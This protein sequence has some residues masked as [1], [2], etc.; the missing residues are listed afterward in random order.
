MN[1]AIGKLGRSIFFNKKAWS[2]T[3]GDEE[4]PLLYTMLAKRHPEHT[5]YLIGRSDITRYRA[6]TERSTV[7][8]L[9]CFFGDDEVA[10]TSNNL[11]TN[12]VDLFED[13][14][15]E[16]NRDPHKWLLEKIE[17]I[18]LKFDL[19]IIYHGPIA[20]V[21]VP[22]VGIMRVDGKGPAQTLDMFSKYYAPVVHTFNVMQFPWIGLCGDPK[23]VPM[24]Q[25]D[26]LN[27]PKIIMSQINAEFTR[28][29]IKSYTESLERRTVKETY[30]YCGIETIYM[31]DSERYD[32]RNVK[33]DIPFTIGLNGGDSRNDFIRE[34][35]IDKGRTDIKVYGV[36]SKE[37]TDA[38]P[39]MFEEK[40]ISDAHDEFMRTKY[41]II[42]PPHK[43]T[44]N[45]V[46][47]K[48]W[49]MIQYGIVPFFHPK[50]DTDKL[51]PVPSILRINSPDQMYERMAYLDANPDEYQ[52]IKDLMWSLLPDDLFN[53]EFIYGQVQKQ[54]KKHVGFGL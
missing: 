37:F 39:D 1:I 42:P 27:E 50:Y 52:K 20:G 26:F 45:F 41:T 24:V 48:F 22:D 9:D 35:F 38:Y 18:G 43:P 44:G 23:Y 10:D 34:W 51:F 13:I 3:S 17:R 21:G 15:K 36:W 2:M 4:A 6:Q 25:R 29:R 28:S 16:R 31:L 53:G 33:K 5:F 46:T 54:L 30:T 47:Q 11:P 40:R 14:P 19:G 32:W 12:I 7:G 8:T 49:K